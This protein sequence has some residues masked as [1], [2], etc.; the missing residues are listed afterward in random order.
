M[1]EEKLNRLID[2]YILYLKNNSN[3]KFDFEERNNRKRFYQSF[4]KNKLINMSDDEIMEMAEDI[5]DMLKKSK[6]GI[7]SFQSLKS[8]DITSCVFNNGAHF[9]LN[10]A[11]TPHFYFKLRN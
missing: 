8:I 3:D 9:S 6:S 1:N 10:Y 11:Y 5:A 4:D 2:D 7:F